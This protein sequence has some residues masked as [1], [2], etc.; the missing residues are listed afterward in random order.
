MYTTFVDA[1]V[2]FEIKATNSITRLHPDSKTAGKEINFSN[3][4]LKPR[5]PKLELKHRRSD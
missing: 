3:K 5:L 2:Y 4:P 1:A